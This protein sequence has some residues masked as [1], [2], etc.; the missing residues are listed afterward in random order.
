MLQGEHHKTL[1]RYP[2]VSRSEK[3]RVANVSFKLV[4]QRN[5]EAHNSEE[6]F[7]GLLASHA[8]K[9]SKHYYTYLVCVFS[10]FLDYAYEK[11]IEELA[12]ESQEKPENEEDDWEQRKEK[13]IVVR[14]AIEERW[15]KKW[16]EQQN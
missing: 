11:N 13:S 1:R 15:H 7:A 6:R 3:H 12:I 10:F 16:A 5:S 4:A 9:E 8:F 14:R 2:D